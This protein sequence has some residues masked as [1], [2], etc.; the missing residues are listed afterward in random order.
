M[1]YATW[2]RRQTYLL[3]WGFL[4]E[5]S[6]NIWADMV[7]KAA[8]F[9]RYKSMDISYRWSTSHEIHIYDGT[10]PIARLRRAEEAIIEQT[11]QEMAV[12]AH[13][14][15][16]PEAA[17]VADACNN[18]LYKRGWADPKTP[19]SNYPPTWANPVHYDYPES[20]KG[21]PSEFRRAIIADPKNAMAHINLGVIL[22]CG[23]ERA[24]SLPEAHLRRAIKINPKCPVGHWQL[25]RYLEFIC[26][27]RGAERHYR[28]AL[29]IRRSSPLQGRL[30][31][32]SEFR[33]S[34]G[35]LW[36]LHANLQCLAVEPFSA[37]LDRWVDH[38]DLIGHMGAPGT[39]VRGPGGTWMHTMLS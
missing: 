24:G 13:V 20:M 14:A 3:I 22:C 26:D 28:Q 27:Y 6:K 23:L 2:V 25:A 19:G 9:M 38:V 16:A 31:F 1:V 39:W 7:S 21:V 34:N 4:D 32:S 15:T 35:E 11:L 12:R 36:V 10:G 29:E 30:N 5:E 37:A 33:V 8:I 18:A 17:S